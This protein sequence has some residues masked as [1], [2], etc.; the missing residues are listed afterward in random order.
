MSITK[1]LRPAPQFTN[2]TIT[3]RREATVQI[4]SYHPELVSV[5]LQA[6]VPDGSNIPE[7]IARL[8]EIVAAHVHSEQAALM[9][10]SNKVRG[11]GA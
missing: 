9:A 1:T 8:D 5:T 2:V 6:D 4:T 7:A 3:A 11:G 10:L